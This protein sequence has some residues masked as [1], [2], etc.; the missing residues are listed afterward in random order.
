MIAVAKMTVAVV[1]FLAG[2]LV[3]YAERLMGLDR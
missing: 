1:C 2:L 3:G